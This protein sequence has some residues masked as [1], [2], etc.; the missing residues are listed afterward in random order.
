MTLSGLRNAII[1]LNKGGVSNGWGEKV[2]LYIF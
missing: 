1:K 2:V